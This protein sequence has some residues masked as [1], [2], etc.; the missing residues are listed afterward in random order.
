MADR[1][2]LKVEPREMTGKGAARSLRREG[3]VPGV[4]Y[5]H[6]RETQEC[7]V[8]TTEIEKVLT[9]ISW[10]NTI[11]DLKLDGG[12]TPVLIRE[13]QIHPFKPE[14][15]HVDFLVIRKG[16]KL[17]VEVPIRLVGHAPGVEEGGIMEQPR[18]E[19]EIRCD[20]DA[21]PEVLELDVSGLEVGDS[22]SIGDLVVPPGVEILDEPERTICAV[23][24]P[25]KV[26]EPEPV[27]AE[28]VEL[29]AVIG[30]EGEEIEEAEGAPSP[31]EESE[32]ASEEDEE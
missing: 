3:F 24:P 8:D 9:S 25:T 32:A 31:E 6:G 10:E 7:K 27:E 14:V 19:V 18:H 15:L 2:S 30:E 22:L 29:E 12:A 11:I 16:E 5:G 1:V 4:I 23:V 28:E 20:P 13:V 26:E 17:R 21:I